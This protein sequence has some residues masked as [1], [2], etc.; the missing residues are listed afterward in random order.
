MGSDGTG[1]K[2]KQGDWQPGGAGGFLL[3]G[4][5]A[6]QEV[7]GDGVEGGDGEGLV[8]ALPHELQG[9]HQGALP[10]CNAPRILARLR[11]PAACLSA[12]DFV[13]VDAVA[14]MAAAACSAPCTYR[15]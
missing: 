12:S 13:R 11:A 15:L 14:L 4:R 6:V 1:R 8:D 5:G 2:L 9:H 7:P 10:A 3:P